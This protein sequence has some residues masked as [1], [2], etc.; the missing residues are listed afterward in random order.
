MSLV[1]ADS[2]D[3]ER[4]VKSYVP[5]ADPS[6]FSLSSCKTSSSSLDMPDMNSSSESIPSVVSGVGGAASAAAEAAILLLDLVACLSEDTIAS[7]A[8]L[9]LGWEEM[10]S[11]VGVLMLNSSGETR[12]WSVRLEVCVTFQVTQESYDC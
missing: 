4:D 2:D 5:S 9:F 11:T 7:A 1:R 8:F 3:H 12:S 10:V 6:S